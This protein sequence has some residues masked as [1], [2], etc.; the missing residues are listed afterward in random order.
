MNNINNNYD[1]SDFN[2]EIIK[3]NVIIHEGTMQPIITSVVKINGHECKIRVSI[4]REHHQDLIFNPM[5][6]KHTDDIIK[7]ESLQY[8]LNNVLFMRDEKIKKIKLKISNLNN[9]IN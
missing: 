6:E 9:F 5:K 4:S 7:H 1:I 2:I 8:Y 3:K